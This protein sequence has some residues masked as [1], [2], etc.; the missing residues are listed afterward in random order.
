MSTLVKV[1]GRD[2]APSLLSCPFSR[3]LEGAPMKSGHCGCV[4]SKEAPMKWLYWMWRPFKVWEQERQLPP[5]VVNQLLVVCTNGIFPLGLHFISTS[6]AL[7]AL[8][9]DC[10]VLQLLLH[11]TVGLYCIGLCG[12]NCVDCTKHTVHCTSGLHYHLD[13]I[14]LCGLHRWV[15]LCFIV[16]I[17][18][19]G[20][21]NAQV[22]SCIVRHLVPASLPGAQLGRHLLLGLLHKCFLLL[23]IVYLEESAFDIQISSKR[24]FRVLNSAHTCSTMFLVLSLKLHCKKFIVRNLFRCLAQLPILKFN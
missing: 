14:E 17:A 22:V 21:H 10:I 9:L 11:C 19:C 12:L 4:I 13:C 1:Q 18:F 15:A 24:I 5:S 8:H 7:C 3:D 6:I 23:L 16:W 20:L 2:L